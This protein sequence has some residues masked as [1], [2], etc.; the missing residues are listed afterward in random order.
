M[1]A[2]VSTGSISGEVRD[3]SGGVVPGAKVTITQTEKELARV[4]TT[5]SGGA[6]FFTTLPV[7]PYTLEV[8]KAG[9][10]LYRQTGLVLTVAQ[11]AS[12]QVTLQVGRVAQTVNVS[13]AASM[14]NTTD[15]TLSRLVGERQVESLPLNGR[16][17]AALV[18][19]AAGSSD[20]LLNLSRTASNPILQ[21][22]VV[23]PREIA[24]SINGVRG[25]GVYFSLDG[26]NNIDTWQVTGAPFPNPDAV[27]E[28]RVV[29]S[30]YGAEY[31][32]APAGAVDIVTK[33]GT[34][35]FHGDVW[36][37]VRNGDLNARNFF[38]P[39]Q[40]ILKRNQ[41]GAAAGGPI[42]KDKLFVLGS[43]EG[44]RLS[45]VV[46]GQTAFIPTNAERSGDFSAL[47]QQLHDPV[48][49]LPYTNNQIPVQQFDPVIV[50]FLKFIPQSSAPGGKI[51]FSVPANQ[52]DNQGVV[53]IDYS[54][55]KQ[56]FMGRYFIDDISLPKVG[57]EGG[58][59]LPTTQ[60]QA[61]RWQNITFGDTYSGSG[62]LVNEFRLSYV[63]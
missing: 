24:P 45:N 37:F 4:A 26:A 16:Q 29:T 52:T 38:A 46:G 10:S 57:D 3:S 59:L 17:P 35:K 27:Q 18:F 41:F 58:N 7:G 14:V 6:F 19:L 1:R 50:G 20:P 21:F 53:R 36:E 63:R 33:S 25:D 39:T 12:V 54:R 11:V 56:L 32:S 9:F 61:H 15:S 30:T 42:I 8:E 62:S 44:M 48:T 51:Q 28:F 34:N 60:G 43:Y 40:D 22:G 23:H 49:G 13:A 2:Q 47:P 31:V 5:D 55:G